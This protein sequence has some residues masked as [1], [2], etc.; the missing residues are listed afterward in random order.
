[1]PISLC[2]K[3]R[4]V[5]LFDRKPQSLR[6]GHQ[7]CLSEGGGEADKL[8][9]AVAVEGDASLGTHRL[10]DRS[11]MLNRLVC[12][13]VPV[14]V[15][16]LL[17]AVDVDHHDARKW[18]DLSL[19]QRLKEL[20]TVVEPGQC[21]GL[22]LDDQEAPILEATNPEPDHDRAK[23]IP[24]NGET[25]RVDNIIEEEGPFEDIGQQRMDQKLGCNEEIHP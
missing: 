15:V 12:L 6:V 10:K 16:V 8:L 9:A 2:R 1:M 5:S 14:P 19:G 22:S 25:Q 13:D 21:I 24:K 20:A 4:L 7:L 11:E 23:K 17:E 18:L 3:D